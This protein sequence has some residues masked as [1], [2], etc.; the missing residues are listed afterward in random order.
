[1]AQDRGDASNPAQADARPTNHFTQ[2]GQ[3]SPQ[4]IRVPRNRPGFLK[5][6]AAER[7]TDVK[8][9]ENIR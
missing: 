7:R 5:H 9:Q 3:V 4:A 2:V 6:P 8:E 1:L